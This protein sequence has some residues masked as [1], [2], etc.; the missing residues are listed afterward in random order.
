MAKATAKTKTPAKTAAP[1][2]AEGKMI[3][4]GRYDAISYIDPISGKTRTSRGNQDAVALALLGTGPKDWDRI[5]K[6]NDLEQKLDKEY[7]NN[8]QYRMALGAMLRA[9]VKRGEAI[10]I[11]NHPVIKKLDQKISLP[12]KAA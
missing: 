4:P 3:N 6:D 8:G 2:K 5:A 1:V 10:T 9:K 11:G 12:K 7:P